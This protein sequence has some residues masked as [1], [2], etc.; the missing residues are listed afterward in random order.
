MED[1][2]VI[3][4]ESAGY[5]TVTDLAKLRG[6]STCRRPIKSKLKNIVTFVNNKA[7]EDHKKDNF[8]CL[9]PLSDRV[10]LQKYTGKSPCKFSCRRLWGM[11]LT[12]TRIH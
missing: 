1:W 2:H 6:Q 9:R 10:K 5:S 3:L 12:I 8:H 7:K 11:G 4:C